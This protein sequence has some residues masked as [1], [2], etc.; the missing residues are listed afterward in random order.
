MMLLTGN[1]QRIAYSVE[2]IAYRIKLSAKRYPLNA[3]QGFT[4]VEIMVAVAILAFGLVMIYQ[5]FFISADTYGYYL[6]HLRAQLWLDEK[7]WQLQD[8]FRQH[9]FFNPLPSSGEFEAG[10]KE[11]SWAMDYGPV[12]SEKLYKV[13]LLVS[14]QQGFRTVNVPRSAYV[15]NFKPESE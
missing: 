13:N 4:L 14:W 1:K 10:S 12:A 2:R 5:S 8:D 11:F 3:K 9:Q 6:N 7:I 15:S